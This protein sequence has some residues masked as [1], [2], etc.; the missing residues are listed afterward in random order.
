[1]SDQRP[2]TVQRFRDGFAI[3]YPDPVSGKRRRHALN[4]ADRLGAESE[5]RTRWQ[6]GDRSSWTVGR[7]INAYIADRE[8]NEVVTTKR[9]R[10]AWRAMRPSWE[11]VSPHL[12]D[13][14][15]CRAYSVARDRAA[16]TVRY[17]LGMLSVALR[18]AAASPRHLIK[19]VPEIWLPPAPPRKER[20][21]SRAQF[22]AFLEHVKAPHARLY[23]MLG[24]E[25]LAR[26]AAILDLTWDR[27]DFERRLIRLRPDERV[28]TIKRRP[29]LPISD[30]LLPA[31]Q[32]AYEARQSRFV[33]EHGGER[34]HNIKKAFQAASKR[35]GIHVTPYMLRH[36]GAVWKAEDGLSMPE[37][38]Q[39]MGHDDDR[40]TQKHYA[41]F[42]PDYLRR[43][44]NAGA[45]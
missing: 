16:A 38:A 32:A 39:F 5:A 17:E 19:S 21:V 41:R 24:I 30:R 35:S 22:R 43:A 1:M 34:I 37:L 6:L 25:T 29:T 14:D 10:E 31:L 3:V 13:A 9:M 2:Y 33:V 20:H 26:P 7:I 15:M 45:W 28:E 36:S 44:A 18:W 4:A 8:A 42:S 27:V 11:H 23:M 12:I 40:T